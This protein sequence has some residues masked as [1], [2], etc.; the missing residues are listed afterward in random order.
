MKKVKTAK[1]FSDLIENKMFSYGSFTYQ[2]KKHDEA[3]RD[4][5]VNGS[6]IEKYHLE[7]DKE[8]LLVVMKN[9]P[10]GMEKSFIEITSENPLCIRLVDH[11]T[12]KAEVVWTEV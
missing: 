10:F 9:K 7:E 6:A 8:A 1:E 2:F 4:F 11:L 3:S 12:A 5:K